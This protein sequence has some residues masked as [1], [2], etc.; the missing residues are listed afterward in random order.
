MGIFDRQSS[1]NA[2]NLKT[3]AVQEVEMVSTIY[4]RPITTAKN[5]KRVIF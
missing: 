1:S 5:A 4:G 2:E 3:T